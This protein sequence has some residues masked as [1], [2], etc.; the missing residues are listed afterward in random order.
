MNKREDERSPIKTWATP[1]KA[2]LCERRV[3]AEHYYLSTASVRLLNVLW[4]ILA[5]AP[6]WHHWAGFSRRYTLNDVLALCLSLTSGVRGAIE[7]CWIGNLRWIGNACT[8]RHLVSAM[9]PGKGDSY[10]AKKAPK[11]Q[12]KRP[13]QDYLSATLYG[14]SFRQVSTGNPYESEAL[15]L[16]LF[17]RNYFRFL[18]ADTGLHRRL[19]P[20]SLSLPLGTSF[21]CSKKW[22]K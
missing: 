3:G 16:S 6:H 8:L 22:R 19:S 13:W 15:L 9:Q 20:L 7:L 21:A 10:I 5:S 2:H 14:Y 12:V 4:I 17:P 1:L 11:S 18:S